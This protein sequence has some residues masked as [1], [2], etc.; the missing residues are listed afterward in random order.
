MSKKLASQ[1]I[2]LTINTALLDRVD[3]AAEQEYTTRSDIIR[4]ALLWYLQP[5]EFAHADIEEVFKTL[6]QRK[7]RAGLKKYLK[8]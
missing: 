3:Q 1:R 5:H 6:H 4:I 8:G 2:T 7:M